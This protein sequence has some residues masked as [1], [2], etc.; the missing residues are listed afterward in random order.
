LIVVV[1]VLA[2]MIQRTVYV[3]QIV[4]VDFAIYTTAWLGQV[5]I[6]GS[7]MAKKLMWTVADLYVHLVILG[8]SAALTLIVFKISVAT[9]QLLSVTLRPA[10]I[11]C[12]IGQ[13][14]LLIVEEIVILVQVD[15]TAIYLPIVKVTIAQIP[16][17]MCTFAL[18]KDLSI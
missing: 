13:R 2:V 15:L 18:E 1:L 17:W 12:W 16:L 10:T 11:A 5:A 14:V 3:P 7:W 4:Q 6:M 9:Q 8:S